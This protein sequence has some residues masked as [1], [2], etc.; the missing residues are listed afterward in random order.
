MAPSFSTD[1]PRKKYT[2][3][4]NELHFEQSALCFMGMTVNDQWQNLL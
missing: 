4:G 3:P 1:K 2:G